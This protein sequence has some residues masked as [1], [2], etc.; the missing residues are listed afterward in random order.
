MFSL[1]RSP[2]APSGETPPLILLLMSLA[3]T[4]GG[5]KKKFKDVNL[6]F[7]RFNSREPSSVALTACLC[8]SATCSA[9]A[10][11]LY[12]SSVSPPVGH[13]TPPPLHPKCQTFYHTAA[14]REKRVG[15]GIR[16]ETVECFYHSMD[17]FFSTLHWFCRH[18]TGSSFLCLQLY[19]L[20]GS[21]VLGRLM[22]DCSFIASN[23]I[24]LL[25]SRR[26]SRLPISESK[27]DHNYKIKTTYLYMF[28]F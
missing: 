10:V 17:Y 9:P 27:L 24:V 4:N 23:R 14:G 28:F 18:S 2:S 7:D 11:S 15:G 21:S 16:V 26:Q 12:T 1:P 19:F 13:G 6:W 3:G 8:V 5:R 22:W 20:L 25:A